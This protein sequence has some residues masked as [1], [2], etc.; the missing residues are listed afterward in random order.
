M[1]DARE[2]SIARTTFAI[3]V[4]VDQI[5]TVLFPILIFVTIKQKR[6]HSTCHLLIGIYALCGL[7]SKLQI[8]LP[9]AVF[10]LPGPGKISL[11]ICVI[12]QIFTVGSCM[13]G[14][15]LMLIIGIDRM[16]AIFSPLWLEVSKFCLFCNN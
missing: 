6:L 3:N 11:L 2:S 8:L 1:T 12:V 5:G 10:I 4:G 15:S 16:M 13:N 7:L 9:F 14:F